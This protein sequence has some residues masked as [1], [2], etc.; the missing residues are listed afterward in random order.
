[1]SRQLDQVQ[2]DRIVRRN[3]QVIKAVE[4]ELVGSIQAAGS[5]LTGFSVRYAYGEVLMTLRSEVGDDH[6]VCF[7]VSD[8]LSNCLVKAVRD[9]HADRLQWR[10]DKYAK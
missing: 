1:M 2:E 6:M 10:A 8:C 9:A 3:K 7:V 5:E 4:F